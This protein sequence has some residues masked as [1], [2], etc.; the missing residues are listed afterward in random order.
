MSTR[1]IKLKLIRD[2]IPRSLKT[3][4]NA[5]SSGRLG[6]LTRVGP[7]GRRGRDLWVD[8]DGLVQWASDEGINLQLQKGAAHH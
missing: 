1:L 3:L 8:Q 6:W 2:A 7:D 5:H 4:Y